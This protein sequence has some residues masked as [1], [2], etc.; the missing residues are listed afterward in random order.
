QGC[1]ERLL[2]LA[3]MQMHKSCHDVDFAERR[4]PAEVVAHAPASRVRMCASTTADPDVWWPILGHH[5]HAVTV[6]GR[7]AGQRT[8]VECG[9]A[10]CRVCGVRGVHPGAQSL[11]VAG[12]HRLGEAHPADPELLQGG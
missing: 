10:F 4:C 11:D 6:E 7:G 5:P 8:S 9:L 3:A 12:A 2:A 1:E